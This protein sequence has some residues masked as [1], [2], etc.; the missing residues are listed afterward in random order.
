MTITRYLPDVGDDLPYETQVYSRVPEPW[1]VK[2][3][4]LHDDVPL[5]TAAWGKLYPIIERYYRN[6]EICGRTYADFFDSLQSAYDVDADTL[7]RHLK[8]Y[9]DDIAN[10]IL[11]RTIKN[12]HTAT[13]SD[14]GESQNIEV[15]ADENGNDVP[16]S[17]NK[18]TNAHT[19]T[20]EDT[21]DWSDVGVMPNYDMMNGFLNNNI[22]V[23]KFAIRI[24]KN[25]FYFMEGF[26]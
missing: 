2:N 5:T 23:A 4:V 7:E 8:V 1:R 20:T 14:N 9:N 18:S 16:D 15:P 25:C 3:I 26:Y 11:G 17:K 22:T 19:E 21:Q 13:V 24:F 12:T 10:P 6:Y